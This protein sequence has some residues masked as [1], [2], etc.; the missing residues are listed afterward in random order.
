MKFK[1]IN[2]KQIQCLI[3][4]DELLEKGMDI[5]DFLENKDKTE[6][7]LREIVDEAQDVL[8]I[9][10]MGHYF[11]VQMHILKTGNV[12]IVINLEGDDGHNEKNLPGDMTGA[13]NRMKHMLELMNENL[14]EQDDE[15]DWREIE[16]DLEDVLSSVG[17]KIEETA[18]TEY[19]DDDGNDLKDGAESFADIAARMP[20]GGKSDKIQDLLEGVPIIIRIDSLEDCIRMSKTMHSLERIKSALYKYDDEFYF[21]ISFKGNARQVAGQILIVSEFAEDIFVQEDGGDIIVE[22]GKCILADK[23]IDT[24]AGL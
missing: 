16:K 12:S 2:E 24:L 14:A 7:F 13:M 11:S 19:V 22:H 17:K 9:E 1:K 3:S 15:D 20:K 4:Q 10:E 6:E 23:A 8:E 21:Q 18:D 5:D